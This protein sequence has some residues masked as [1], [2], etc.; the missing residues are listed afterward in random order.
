MNTNSTKPDL[1]SDQQAVLASDPALGLRDQDGRT[2]LHHAVRARNYETLTR[3]LKAKALLEQ[4]DDAGLTPLAT[5]VITGWLPGADRL[6]DAAPHVFAHLDAHGGTLLHCAAISGTPD[7]VD[8]VFENT[9]DSLD[10]FVRRDRHGCTPLRLTAESAKPD[11]VAV[12]SQLL[13]HAADQD[14]GEAAITQVLAQPDA[15]E[16]STPLNEAV[17]H[18]NPKMCEMLL[19]WGAEPLDKHE[20]LA[21]EQQAEAKSEAAEPWREILSLLESKRAAAPNPSAPGG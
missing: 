11:A 14:D 9:P 4:R 6:L 19:N 13:R 21:K 15:K 12:A 7:A 18:G 5:A 8:W 17:C 16:C 20:D 10:A 3:C 2:I 1:R